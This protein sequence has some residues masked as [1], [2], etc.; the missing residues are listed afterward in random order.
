MNSYGVSG[1]DGWQVSSRSKHT[2]FM[3]GVGTKNNE[4]FGVHYA[5]IVIRSPQD[6]IG[7]D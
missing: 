3:W 7:N 6:S 2:A 5:V 4:G 1:T